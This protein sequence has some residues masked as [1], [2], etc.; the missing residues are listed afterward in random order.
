MDRGG[1]TSGETRKGKRGGKLGP[2]QEPAIDADAAGFGAKLR[3]AGEDPLRQRN[4]TA[5]TLAGRLEAAGLDHRK[6]PADLLPGR[7]LASARFISGSPT[8]LVFPDPP[9]DAGE[10]VRSLRAAASIGLP[11]DGTPADA[12]RESVLAEV[13]GDEHVRVRRAEGRTFVWSEA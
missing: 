11:D 2:G 9:A 5:R 13:Y 7:A 6:V 10:R 1:A 3:G 4:G 8:D 12:L